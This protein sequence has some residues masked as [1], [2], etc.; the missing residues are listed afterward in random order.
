MDQ[1]C[2]Q[3]NGLAIQYLAENQA[4]EKAGYVGESAKITFSSEIAGKALSSW[5]ISLCMQCGLLLTAC[6]V[7]NVGNPFIQMCHI[8][9]LGLLKPCFALLSFTFLISHTLSDHFVFFIT[10]NLKLKRF[11]KLAK[12]RGKLCCND[13]QIMRHKSN[14]T[15]SLL[16]TEGLSELRWSKSIMVV[17]KACVPCA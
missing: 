6:R 13:I 17:K 7:V 15:F 4:D 16:T 8:L 10:E 12:T 1:I 14:C 11:S 2:H 9:G 3:T 5:H